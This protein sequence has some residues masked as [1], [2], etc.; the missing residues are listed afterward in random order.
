VKKFYWDKFDE[1]IQ[2]EKEQVSMPALQSELICEPVWF[3]DRVTD[4]HT[5]AYWPA[6]FLQHWPASLYTPI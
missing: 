6:Q 5:D 3:S 1:E 2:K 4:H